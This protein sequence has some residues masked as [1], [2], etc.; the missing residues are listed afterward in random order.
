MHDSNDPKPGCCRRVPEWVGVSV[1][2]VGDL[3]PRARFSAGRVV[4]QALRLGCTGRLPMKGPWHPHLQKLAFSHTHARTP[5]RRQPAQM[6]SQQPGRTFRRSHFLLYLVLTV[7]LAIIFSRA[8]PRLSALLNHLGVRTS[9]S[10]GIPG[11]LRG[12]LPLHSYSTVSQ[13]NQDHID[14][15][16]H[17]DKVSSF[18]PGSRHYFSFWPLHLISNTKNQTSSDNS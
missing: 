15:V 7:I 13:G 14:H 5:D 10:V 1:I 8:T 17:C 2:Q 16:S 4:G 18:P 6:V 3:R 9:S 12:I 11:P